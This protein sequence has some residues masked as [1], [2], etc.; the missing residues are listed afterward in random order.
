MK[1]KLDAKLEIKRIEILA[2]KEDIFKQSD[3][4]RLVFWLMHQLRLQ[5]KRQVI[6]EADAEKE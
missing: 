6:G 3:S 2:L 5:T 1:E 4:K